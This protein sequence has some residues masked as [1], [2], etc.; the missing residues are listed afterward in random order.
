M[1]HLRSIRLLTLMA[2]ALFALAACRA[3]AQ[4]GTAAAGT[5]GAT[6]AGTGTAVPTVGTTPTG[7]PP[8]AGGVTLALNKSSYL[9]GDMIEVTIKN[10]LK[11]TIFA[12]DHRSDCTMVQLERL[13]N[14]IWQPMAPCRLEIATRIVPLAPNSSLPQM[15]T[16][17]VGKGAPS[18][19]PAGT[20]RIAFTYGKESGNTPGPQTVV[21]SATFSV[22]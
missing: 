6:P 15:L 11:M 9:P 12:A 18:A 2:I 17:V 1:Q 19:W 4:P 14:G 13:N 22:L 16:P 21:Y 5:P 8:T 3:P 7:S 10:E 20:Y